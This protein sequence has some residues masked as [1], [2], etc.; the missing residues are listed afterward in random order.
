[1]RLKHHSD[2]LP[3]SAADPLPT[4]F[5]APEFRC[6]PTC[7]NHSQATDITNIFGHRE[8]DFRA[9]NAFSPCRQGKRD[10][11]QSALKIAEKGDHRGVDLRRPLLLGY[12]AAARQYD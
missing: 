5:L 12:V 7:E 11:A 3:N 10:L 1:M 8:D 4:L 9:Q 6:R 2:P